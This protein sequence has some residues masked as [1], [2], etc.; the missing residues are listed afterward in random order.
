MYIYPPEGTF[1]SETPT[2]WPRLVCLGASFTQMSGEDPD[3]AVKLK[4][5]ALK[6]GTV[7][8]DLPFVPYKSAM[9]GRCMTHPESPLPL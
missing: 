1:V 9:P 6:P 5:C 8:A 7:E 4:G 3:R 2:V